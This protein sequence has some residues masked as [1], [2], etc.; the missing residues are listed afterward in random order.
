M[1]K[2]SDIRGSTLVTFPK[3]ETSG[4]SDVLFVRRHEPGRALFIVSET[5][6]HPLSHSWPDQQA[7]HGTAEI[8]GTEFRV[9]D[10]ITAALPFA[11]DNRELYLDKQ[12]PVR[13]FD[14]MWLFLVAHIIEVPDDYDLESMLS[15][16]ARLQVDRERRLL[17]SATHT[18]THV[19]GLA[20]NKHTAD[21]WRKTIGSDSL[22]HPD[23]DKYAM[24][25]STIQPG[26]AFDRYRFGKSLKKKGFDGAQ[27]FERVTEIEQLVARQVGEWIATG[28]D[29]FI[30]APGPTLD[31]PRSWQVKLD[32]MDVDF[33]CGGTHIN[34]FSQ[35]ENVTVSF[36]LFPDEQE[37]EMHTVPQLRDHV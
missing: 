35:L 31:A 29:V 5:P 15:K 4:V 24:D 1:S 30:A 28:Q 26:E 27:F 12:I 3:G 20:L 33:P 19:A 32:G 14:P 13:K 36:T 23:L 6:F 8:D 34:N 18:S 17:L 11:G 9:V 2:L 21:L 37:M 22:G 10:T 7:D 25:R 16:K